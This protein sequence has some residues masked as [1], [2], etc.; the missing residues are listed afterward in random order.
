MALIIDMDMPNSCWKCEVEHLVKGCPC[1]LGYAE[2][3][4]YCSARHKDCPLKSADDM[5]VEIEARL[6]HL[7]WRQKAVTDIADIIHK[8]IKGQNNGNS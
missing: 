4:D 5:V 2:A 3:S 8:Y 6:R 1:F 7:D